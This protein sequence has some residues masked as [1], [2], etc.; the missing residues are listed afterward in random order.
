[1]P[2]AHD[3]TSRRDI[4]QLVDTFYARVRQDGLVGPIFDEVAHVDW[5]VHLPKMYDFWESV[6]FGAATF[7][8]NPLGVHLALARLT[9]LTAEAFDRWVGL[10]HASVDDLFIGPMAHEAKLRATRI[11]FTM[12]DHVGAV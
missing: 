9:P 10:F 4:E 8:G 5:T 3:I 11:A 7:K 6:L 1:M 12:R 2:T